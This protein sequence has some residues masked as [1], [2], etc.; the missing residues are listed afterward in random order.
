MG[1]IGAAIMYVILTKNRSKAITTLEEVEGAG[2]IQYLSSFIHSIN[3]VF[4]LLLLNNMSLK[5]GHLQFSISFAITGAIGLL[6]AHGLGLLRGY[7]GF[8]NDMRFTSTL[9]ISVTFSFSSMRIIGTIVG[10]IKGLII[11]ANVVN[12][13]WLL[14]FILFVFASIFFAVRNVNYA[15]AT[16]FLTPFV[17]ILLDILIP[18]QTLLAQTRILDTLIWSMLTLFGVFIIWTFSKLFGITKQLLLS[19]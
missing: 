5:S 12:N 9:D 11:T 13:I 8:N 10:A 2:A 3:Q 16:L 15:L 4:N 18:D 1:N 7:W 17:L 19:T 6:I 14:S